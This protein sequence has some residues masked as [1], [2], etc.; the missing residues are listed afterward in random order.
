LE[1]AYTF[2]QAERL[3]PIGHSRGAVRL[4]KHRLGNLTDGQLEILRCAKG[5]EDLVLLRRK[6]GGARHLLS[7]MS[8]IT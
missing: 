1:T 8:E 7:E 2:N 4:Q 6:T 3:K 5:K